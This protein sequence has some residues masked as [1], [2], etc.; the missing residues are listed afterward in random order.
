MKIRIN[1]TH[2]LDG[3][4]ISHEMMDMQRNNLKVKFYYME[5]VYVLIDYSDN[6]KVYNFDNYQAFRRKL[7]IVIENWQA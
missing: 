4:V 1:K 5:N 3:V 6:R 7:T 2:L